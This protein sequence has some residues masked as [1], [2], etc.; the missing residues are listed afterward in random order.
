MM[1]TPDLTRPLSIVQQAQS[2]DGEGG[3]TLQTFGPTRNES[4]T[5]YSRNGAT[6]NIVSLQ[7]VSPD[8]ALGHGARVSAFYRRLA[9]VPVLD[10]TSRGTREQ[11]LR[12]E[13]M[14][15]ISRPVQIRITTPAA[16]PVG[17]M[18]AIPAQVG[19]PFGITPFGTG[20]FGA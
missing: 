9:E 7:R 8:L 11:V 5:Q 20:G 4:T 12:A 13:L 6:H 10:P 17:A 2:P 19:S 18:L 3:R 1:R 14:P 16:V 15:T